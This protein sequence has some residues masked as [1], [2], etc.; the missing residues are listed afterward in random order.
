M[1]PQ[2]LA[3]T[4]AGLLLIGALYMALGCFASAL[5]QSQI[6]AAMLSYLLG[7]ALFVVAAGTGIA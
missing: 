1:A 4:F 7:L 2:V 6:V 3:S 5:T